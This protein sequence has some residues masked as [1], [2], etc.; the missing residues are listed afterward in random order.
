[1]PVFHHDGI[2][3]YYEQHGVGQPLVMSHGMTGDLN[4]IIELLGEISGYSLLV[5]DARHHGRTKPVGAA[6][7]ISF[8]T[9][10]ADLAVLM[11]HVGIERA[12]V[13]GVSMGAGVSMRLALDRPKLV[14]ALILIRPAWLDQ[15]SPATLI[16]ATKLGAILG[17]WGV[18][19]GRR[20]FLEVNDFHTLQAQEPAAAAAW[21]EQF[22]KPK[23]AELSDR[24]RRMPLCCPIRNWDEVS[25]CRVPTLVVGNEDDYVHPYRYAEQWARHL[26]NSKLAKVTSKLVDSAAHR[27]DVRI[28]VERFLRDSEA[29]DNFRKETQSLNVAACP[30]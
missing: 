2:E 26:P 11:D 1:M 15:P 14:T 16:P 7:A 6:D 10:A 27:R 23:A 3:F 8:E 22:D 13:G 17:E 25:R 18:D 21:L 9:F 19:E 20:R 30:R 4:Q 12:V 24:L 29:N 28:E 5:W